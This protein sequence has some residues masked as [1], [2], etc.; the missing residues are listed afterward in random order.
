MSNYW[1]KPTACHVTAL[2]RQGP[3]HSGR[4]LAV[5]WAAWDN[6]LNELEP[7]RTLSAGPHSSSEEFVGTAIGQAAGY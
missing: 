7:R 5:R 1:L 3:R 4:G 6:D 2:A